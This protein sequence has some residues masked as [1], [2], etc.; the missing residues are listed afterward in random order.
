MRLK[1][2]FDDEF[3]IVMRRRRRKIDDEDFIDVSK[4]LWFFFGE[5]DNFDFVVVLSKV[6]IKGFL[7]EYK[8]NFEL[9]RVRIIMLKWIF[10]IDMVDDFFRFDFFKFIDLV[11]QEDYEKE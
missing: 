11:I 9:E 4:R 2:D 6:L 7:K 3:E 5:V 1:F 8:K 10:L